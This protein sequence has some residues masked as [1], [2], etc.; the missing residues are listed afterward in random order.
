MT[1]LLPHIIVV[2]LMLIFTTLLL[3]W[4]VKTGRA[5]NNM[6]KWFQAL[7]CLIPGYLWW[8]TRTIK[9]KL[10]V[11][12]SYFAAGFLI[13]LFLVP[14]IFADSL[15]SKPD[16]DW[17]LKSQEIKTVII[18]GFGF[19]KDNSGK[20][21]PEAS[22]EFLYRLAREQ[23]DMKYLIMQEGVYIAA[24][25]DSVSIRNAGIELIRMHPIDLKKDVNTFEASEYAI[26]QMAM[27]NQKKAIV[28][29]HSMQI[30]RAIADLNKIAKSIPG[31]ADFEFIEPDVPSTPFPANTA[32]KRTGSKVIYRFIELYGSRLRD[33]FVYN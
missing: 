6:F 1:V 17:K 20:M 24:I 30:R 13:V 22:N 25:N 33:K 21:T 15:G 8:R 18:F 12:F 16:K 14:A 4:I 31:Y 9:D 32:Q 26:R 27:V 5:T 23:S 28:Y 11:T 2:I 10:L 3:I 19:G 7:L 29:A